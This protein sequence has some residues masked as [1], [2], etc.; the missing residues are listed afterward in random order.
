MDVYLEMFLNFSEQLKFL[1]NW[2]VKKP[3]G[4][5]FSLDVPAFPVFHFKNL[6]I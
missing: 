4:Q 5:L 2:L 6:N 3:E 1:S